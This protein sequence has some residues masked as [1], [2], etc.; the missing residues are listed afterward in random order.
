MKCCNKNEKSE[1]EFNL[2]GLICY[3]FKHSKKDLFDAVN[4]GTE[5]EIMNDIKSKMK[6]PGCFCEKSNPS[7]KCCMVDVMAFVDH[8]KSQRN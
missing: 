5:K 2:D 7:G 4:S 1:I 8:V 6:N 3:C